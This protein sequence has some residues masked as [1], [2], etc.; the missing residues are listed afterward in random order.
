VAK[1]SVELQLKE[2][3]DMVLCLNQ[4]NKTLT[5][6]IAK[7]NATISELNKK[8][9]N[10]DLEIDYLKQKLYGSSSEKIK[11]SLE[12][13]GQ[14]SLFSFMDDIES[15]AVPVEA[16]VIEV[17]AHKRERKP[18][19]SY[20]ELF[21][22]LPVER[23]TVDTLSA[24]DKIC[25]ACG[26]EMVPIGTEVI[27]TEIRF[28]EPK[29]TRVE[30]MATTYEC[31]KCKLTEDPQFI[32]DNGTP[33]LIEHSYVSEP[34]AAW[35]L[36]QK[37]VMAAPFYRQEKFFSDL[38]VD[39][40]RTTM[41]SWAIECYMRYFKPLT[42]YFHR[43]ILERRFIM[44]D[45]TPIQVLKEEDRR[46]QTKSYVW[47][48][49]TGE[50]GL[51]PIIYFHYTPSRAGEN[52]VE[53]LEGAAENTYLMVDGY[54]GYNKVNNIKH[55]CCYAHIRRKFYDAI[56]KGQERNIRLPAVQ[57]V[58]YCDKLFSY[59]REYKEKGLSYKQR[60]N[61][62]LKHA[63]PVIEAFLS[64]LDTQHAGD[65]AKFNTALTYVN[66]RRN[67]L[68]TYLED[69][70][71]SLS[72][73]LTE[74]TIRPITCGRKNWLFSDTPEGAH[75]SMAVY[76]IIENAKA[77]NLKTYDYIKFVLESRPNEKMTDEELEAIAPWS[78]AAQK[79]CG[80]TE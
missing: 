73:N 12:Q 58:A 32:K 43:R 74:N 22:D 71:C 47:A 64:W 49:R 9:A 76:T 55:C 29:L 38:G 25:P 66:N 13:D 56:P 70:R 79:A 46:P 42:D 41:A 10:K 62:R 80:K 53:L 67:Q 36:N 59:E 17:K 65:N 27:R 24:E 57:A 5:D 3:K 6:T 21:K 45:E 63:K 78:N 68:M 19:K 51:P 26:T 77:H 16:E 28:T 35:V 33:A 39:I 37:F 23:I 69:G 40:S 14:M 75:A 1:S 52:A 60:Y 54:S 30:Y 15:P 31:P 4:S 8:L 44:M 7:L 72:N 2:L 11:R 61:R 18:K 50:D 34:L 20:D 48:Q